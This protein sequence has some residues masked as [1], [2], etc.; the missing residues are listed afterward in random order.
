MRK[1]NETE[2]SELICILPHLGNQTKVHA[3]SVQI[4]RIGNQ[5]S[6]DIKKADIISAFS[7][8]S[9]NNSVPLTVNHVDE[10]FA[11]AQYQKLSDAEK[12]SKPSFEKMPGGV[13]VSLGSQTIKNG[14]LVR[15][16]VEYEITIIDKEPKKPLPFGLFF[17]QNGLLFNN[18]LK[19]HS[20]SKS[21]L[22][23]NYK[24]KLQPFEEKTD[25]VQEGY[26]VAFQSNNKAYSG[27]ATFNSEMMAQ[28]F[29]NE[30]ISINPK[31][32]KDIHVIS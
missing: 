7:K 4:D 15:K 32:K 22:S 5:D 20:A 31:L 29:M 19:G 11:R 21:V 27:S 13:S 8:D 6:N 16:I 30:Q 24:Q 26:T 1:F 2:T 28:S 18:F 17:K 12:L 3:P 23:K 10:D 9:L 14:H 25:V